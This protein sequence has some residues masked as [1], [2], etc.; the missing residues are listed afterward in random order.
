MCHGQLLPS[1]SPRPDQ[2]SEAPLYL[3]LHPP[4][5]EG[6]TGLLGRERVDLYPRLAAGLL[7][8]DN[9]TLSRNRDTKL[10]DVIGIVSPGLAFIAGETAGSNLGDTAIR[11]STLTLELGR[12]TA[13]ANR[14]LVTSSP[15]VS[16]DYSAAFSFFAEHSS[17]NSIE[18]AARILMAYPFPRL[19]LRLQQDVEALAESPVDVGTRVGHR[20][21]QTLFDATYSLSELTSFQGALN[22]TISD[23][24]LGIGR[25][26]W[27]ASAFVNYAL[28]QMITAGGGVT[29]GLLE[30]DQL[31]TQYYEQARVRM[32]YEATEFIHLDASGGLEWRQFGGARSDALSPVFDISGSYAPTERTVLTLSAGRGSESS[33]VLLGQNYTDSTVTLSLRQQIANRVSG[34][35]MVSYHNLSYNAATSGIQTSRNDDYY[36]VRLAV[37]VALAPRFFLGSFYQLRRNVST[38]STFDYKNNQI[39][40]ALSWDY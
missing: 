32:G 37:N 15:G 27:Q 34:I 5:P 22:Q 6:A 7:Y 26:E 3:P 20:T 10:G 8:N 30:P 35:M 4:R 31:P 1:Q 40:I 16:V 9:V 17:L 29:V 18:H 24:D 39:G 19:S 28:T 2:Q 36:L 38:E 33:V 13:A 21:Y 14:A 23:Y 12:P 25:R 11:N